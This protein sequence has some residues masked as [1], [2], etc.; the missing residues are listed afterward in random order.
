MT[1]ATNRNRLHA[2]ATLRL[3]TAVLVTGGLAA[4]IGV[5]EASGAQHAHAKSV[6]IS[7]YKS[8]K[9]GTILVD[10]KTLYTLKPN[11]NACTATCHKFWI[12]VLL[13]KGVTRAT[14]GTGVSAAKLG[15]V[16]VAGG[17]QVTYGA[18]GALLVLPGQGPRSGEGQC[19]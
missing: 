19:H 4:A 1:Q 3:A 6:V 2:N 8:A 12:E 18:Q 15:T 9:L 13:P 11:A 7:T 16:K 5:T 17:L 10:G 14:A